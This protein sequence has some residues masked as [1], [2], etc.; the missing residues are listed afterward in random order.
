[1]IRPGVYCSISNRNEKNLF[2][3]VTSAGG[4]GDTPGPHPGPGST[5]NMLLKDSRGVL[6]KTFDGYY[7][8]VK[9]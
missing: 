4:G 7:L 3:R 2:Y 5:K 9:N 8:T 6:L 1:M